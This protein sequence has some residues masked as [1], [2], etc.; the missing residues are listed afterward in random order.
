MGFYRDFQG[1]AI[2]LSLKVRHC[3]FPA[4]GRLRKMFFLK[5]GLKKSVEPLN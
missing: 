3:P 4:C 5:I 1:N 2:V